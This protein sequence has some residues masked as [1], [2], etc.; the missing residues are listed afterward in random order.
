MPEIWEKFPE[1]LQVFAENFWADAVGKPGNV[2]ARLRDAGNKSVVYGIVERYSD[3][4]DR[5]SG[6]LG[7]QC[8]RCC[9]RCD[10]VHLEPDQLVRKAR[11]SVH[12]TFSK[13]VLDDDILALDPSEITQSL[14]ERLKEAGGS[15]SGA[16]GEVP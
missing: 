5:F 3:N 15:S 1:E 8:G 12:L 2:P 11:Q 13:P 10:E 14:L 7:C 16:R 9:R 6:V 4:G